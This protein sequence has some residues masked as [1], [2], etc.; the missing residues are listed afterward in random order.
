MKKFSLKIFATI[1]FM[2]LFIGSVGATSLGL[3]DE[4]VNQEGEYNSIRF[5]GG[6]NVNNKATIDGISFGF[7]NNVAS[8]GKVTYGV[9][10]GNVININENVEKD[11]FVA[12][13]NITISDGAV[14]GRDAFI[15]GS[16]INIYADV[17]RDLRAGGSI[18]S[19][20]G[21]TIGGDAI[22]DA[23]RIV[24]DENTTITGKLSYPTNAEIQGL[25]LAT[26]GSVETRIVEDV[27]IEETVGAFNT[28][29]F[30]T[31]LIAAIV[32]MLI[33]LSVCPGLKDKLNKTKVEASEIFKTSMKGLIVL[34]VVPVVVLFTLFT[35]LLT[36]VSLIVLSLYCICIYLSSLFAAYVIG[37]TIMLKGFK[38]KKDRY[39][40]S[41]MLG[42][43]LVRLLCLIPIIGGLLSFVLLIYGLGLIY[44]LINTNIKK[45]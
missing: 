40:L 17:A 38:V 44:V 9:Y 16:T 14:L 32:T 42:I 30:V 20:K 22:I 28:Y 13:N 35:G 26:I 15:A 21:V 12:G 11:L 41:I 45:K 7:G 1:L 23:E 8:N 6:N 34:I 27:D 2:F 24:L 29:I 3:F 39:V 31:W 18:V 25:N 4:T 19:L 36:P 43:V 10:A 37:Y 5:I 33:L